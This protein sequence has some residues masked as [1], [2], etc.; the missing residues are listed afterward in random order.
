MKHVRCFTFVNIYHQKVETKNLP[1]AHLYKLTC[2]SSFSNQVFPCV[3]RKYCLQSLI[4]LYLA[5]SHPRGQAE[6]CLKFRKLSQR[7]TWRFYTPIAVIGENRQVCPMERL[8]CT[9]IAAIGVQNRRYLAFRYRR[10]N[11]PAFAKC[12]RCRDFLRLLLRI[13]SK[14]NPSGWAIYHM[15][16]QNCH[17]AAIGEKNRRVCPHQSPA[18]IAGDFRWRSNSQRSA[19]KIARCVAGFSNSKFCTTRIT[20][21][22]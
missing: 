15:S 5:I 11:S 6:N 14:T 8:R 9:P 19:Y 4:T 20:F 17:I 12:A 1:Y 21:I 10:L 3:C 7:H 16:F 2:Q 18:K 22:A 13:A